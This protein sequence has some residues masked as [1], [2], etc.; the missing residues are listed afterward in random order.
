MALHDLTPRPLLLGALVT[1]LSV[2]VA[3]GQPDPP[4]PGDKAAPAAKVRTDADGVPLPDGAIAR[5]GSSRFR[6]D[7]YPYS[8]PVFSADGKQVAVGGTGSVF[9]FD[10]ATGRLNL[11][12]PLP[13]GHH[14]RV[15]RFLSDGK[16]L[17]VGCGDW[18][19]AAQLTVHEL[20]DGK[21]V[22][23]SKFT[24]K[25]QIFAID[26]TPDGSRVL[27]EDRFAKAYLWDIAAHREVWAFDH[28]EASSVLPF[29][30]DG[31]RLVL[32]GSRKAELRDAETGKVVTA[33]PN[34][35]PG[36]GGGYSAALAPDGR[37][38]LAADPQRAV[39]V[40]AAD[41][42]DRVRIYS[43]DWGVERLYFSADSRYLVAPTEYGTQVWDLTSGE[44]KGPV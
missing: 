40:L 29:T 28:P 30:A 14:P 8:P 13:D 41:G 27:V 26:V 7:G 21:A 2:A 6:F 33:F 24:G 11:R 9:V 1:L 43:S 39:A 44:G 5:L 36:F 37:I 38:A 16:R 32:A 19:Q 31:K 15:V 18:R 4:K 34:P 10:A 22:T 12:V 23:T 17:A 20:A 42:K 3:L 25:D 35:G